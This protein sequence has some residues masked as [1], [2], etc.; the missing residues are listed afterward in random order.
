[1]ENIDL[2]ELILR[3]QRITNHLLA[4]LLTEHHKSLEKQ[5]YSHDEMP[6]KEWN[7]MAKLKA[8]AEA[9]DNS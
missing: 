4:T 6:I 5:G 7:I 3:E 1:M 8:S 9:I 2:L